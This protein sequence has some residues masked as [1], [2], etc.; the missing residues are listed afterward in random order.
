[1]GIAL[2]KAADSDD[3]S[4]HVPGQLVTMGESEA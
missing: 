3:V 2:L 4:G 1:M